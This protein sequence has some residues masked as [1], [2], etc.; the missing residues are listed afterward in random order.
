MTEV[1]DMSDGSDGSRRARAPGFIALVL[2]AHLPYVRHPEH[3]RP[4]E[5][6]WLHEAIAECYLPL[7]DLLD[8]LA[9]EGVRAALT[10]SISPPLASMLRDELLGRRFAQHLASLEALA[11]RLA[12]GRDLDPQVLASAGAIG[13]AL[14]F[15]RHRLDGLRRLWERLDGDVLGALLRHQ[16]AGRIE[17]CT[18]AATHAYLPGLLASPASIRAQL[19][20][21]LRSFERLTGRRPLGFWLPECAYAPPLLADL[22][23]AGIRYT[24]LD[25]H[26]LELA[27]PRPPFGVSAPVL[28]QAGVAFFAR[29]PEAARDVWSR[30]TGYPGDPWY[31]EFYRDVGFD[32]PAAALPGELGPND[33][34]LMTGIKLFRITGAGEHKEAYEPVQAEARARAHAAHFVSKRVTALASVDARNPAPL[35]VAPFDA[36]LFGHWWF[37]GPLFLEEVLRA[38]DRSEKQGGVAATT[39]GAHLV[40]FPELAVSEPAASTWG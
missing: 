32:L 18:T 5:E 24:L 34:R 20:L 27:R 25:A 35:L 4:L 12:R 17:L 40:R 26:G 8:R 15:H 3:A 1:S 38:L 13:P 16:D 39:L 33:S 22:A 6:R 10:L 2:H 11:D 31:R 21:G 19:R 30:R 14:A 29:D 28:S 36:E 9:V 23:A 37:E 7:I